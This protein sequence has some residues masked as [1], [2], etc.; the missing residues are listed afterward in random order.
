MKYE[1]LIGPGLLRVE[2]NHWNDGH[3]SYTTPVVEYR[4]GGNYFFF[5]KSFKLAASGKAAI[6]RLGLHYPKSCEMW[7]LIFMNDSGSLARKWHE[8][9]IT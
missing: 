3:L 6:K 2:T 9:L 7:D 1:G 4:Y 5:I 8:K